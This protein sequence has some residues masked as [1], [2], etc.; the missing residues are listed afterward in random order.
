[1]EIIKTTDSERLIPASYFDVCKID[2]K[3]RLEISKLYRKHEVT[4][5]KSVYYLEKFAHHIKLLENLSLKDYCKK[6][7]EIDWP[8]C[9]INGEEVGFKTYGVG[10]KVSKFNATV[11]REFSPKFNAFCE[12]ME[13]E[14]VGSGNPMYGKE[15]WN[16][17]LTAE[18]DERM[19]LLAEK[20]KGRK[21]TEE[22]KKNQSL[23]MFKRLKES[24]P[25]HTM[26]HSEETKAKMKIHTAKLWATGVFSRKSSIEIKMREFLQTLP[27]K[28]EFVEA[29]QAKYYV[30]DFALPNAKIAIECDGDFFHINPMFYPN[31]PENAIQRR[32]FGRD[33]AKNKYLGDRGWIVLRYWE[34]DINAG[35]YKEKLICKLK[36]LNLLKN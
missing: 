4:T 12:K 30:I 3:T 29:F 33:R 24:G 17:G 27:L 9:P 22:T 5:H 23:A 26:P 11:T 36:E 25:L 34:C 28:E 15:A 6:Y 20:G 7:L 19:R 35:T 21:A 18:T 14:R 32:N 8:R 2:G 31:G 13:R 16:S 10:L 1:M